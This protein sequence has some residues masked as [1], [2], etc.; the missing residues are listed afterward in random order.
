MEKLFSLADTAA[1]ASTIPA[2]NTLS[3][4]G[5]P[6]SSAVA[7]SRWLI[8]AALEFGSAERMRKATAATSGEENDVPDPAP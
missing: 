2:P 8:M 5:L 6:R 1:A 3:T 7:M 4:P